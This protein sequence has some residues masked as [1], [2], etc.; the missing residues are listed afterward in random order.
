M[1][2]DSL[3]GLGNYAGPQFDPD[4]FHAEELGQQAQ[5]DQEQ[6]RANRAATLAVLP[7]QYRHGMDVSLDSRSTPIAQNHGATDVH[8]NNATGKDSPTDTS[9]ASGG[10]VLNAK[11]VGTR[12]FLLGLDPGAEAAKAYRDPAL[13]DAA[14][15]DS[16]IRFGPTGNTPHDY[17]PSSSDSNVG[18]SEMDWSK[19]ANPSYFQAFNERP[20]I[21][22]QEAELARA[23]AF[24]ADP[25]ADETAKIAG[26]KAVLQGKAD[27]D[28]STEN[29]RQRSFLDQAEQINQAAQSRL[30]V[31]H[32]SGND[33][34]A[35]AIEKWQA[36]KLLALR[37][38]TGYGEKLTGNAAYGGLGGNSMSGLL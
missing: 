2:Y 12:S 37:Q 22:K 34:L 4:A 36:D 18:H 10:D 9:N 19:I 20:E 14:P 30:L 28:L 7:E 5:R 35:Q 24:T 23:H 13:K 32:A 21:A 15:D 17:K 38:A 8:S 29:K 16:H 1:A 31:A 27:I 26:Q 33:K 3:Y 25:F 6:E 11:A